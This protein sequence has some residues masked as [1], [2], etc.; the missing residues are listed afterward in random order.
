MTRAH[1]QTR[2]W[3][4]ICIFVLGFLAITIVSGVERMRAE[5]GL[6]AIGDADLPAA[7]DGRDAEAAFLRGTEEF[8]RSVLTEDRSGLDRVMLEG[9]RA[10]EL[11]RRIGAAH[12]ISDERTA[13]ARRLAA[14]LTQ[15]LGE[16]NSAYKSALPVQGETVLALRERVSGLTARTTV[17]KT[18]LRSLSTGLSGD[19]QQR[20]GEVR[21][22][23]AA[24]RVFVPCVFA[25]TMGL[26][27]TLVNLTVKRSILAPLAKTQD[28]L[29]HERDLLRILMD[30][31]PDCIY[32]KDAES[33]FLRI[34]RAQAAL[35]GLDDPA[36]ALGHSDADYFDA[37]VARR[38]LAD[39]QRVFQTGEPL[40]GSI[41]YVARKGL[42]RWVTSSKVRVHDEARNTNLIVGISR[43]ITEWKK[44]VEKLE[45]S[46]ESLRL[47]FA[48][49]PHAVWVYDVETLRFL[50]VNEAACRRYGYS[51]EEFERLRVSDLHPPAEASRLETTLAQLW[52]N[53]DQVLPQGAWQYRTQAG[54][55][56]EVDV[57]ARLL[58]F[59]D[60]PAM[61]AVVQDVSD[62]KRLELELQTSQRLEAVGHLAAGIAHEI[63]TPIQFVG[64]N[65][66][67][68]Q[69]AFEDRQAVIKRYGE[70]HRA[71]L[72]GEV[73]RAVLE[74]LEKA[75]Q[76][77]DMEYLDAEVPKA[78]EQSL[79][80]VERIATIVR[81]MKAFAHP[82][83]KE[84]VAADLNKALA[85]TLTV[86]RN[87]LKYVADVETDFG[88]LP[89]VV[90]H[91]ADL[92]Q[93]FLNILVN[94]AHAIGTVMKVSGVK[95]RI[96]V[97]TRLDGDR[98]TVSISDTGCGI[99]EAIRSRVFD[100]FFTTKEV[101]RGTGQGLALARSIVVEKHGGR[102]AFEPNPPQGTTFVVSVPTGQPVPVSPDAAVAVVE[103]MA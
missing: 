5:R 49:I 50:K 85:D 53:A 29:A 25:A 16:V 24:M 87:E 94:A 21:R 22:R 95:G 9:R 69:G 47:L 11:L 13:S 46:E 10:L 52:D 62:R 15:L 26:A 55:P 56:L 101:G 81:A 83:Q 77:A 30:H 63:N 40:V 86:A 32:F 100:Q 41:E 31:I 64:D 48:A 90:C 102:I 99:P 58:R 79:S 61:L 54:D 98:V 97:K 75:I 1:I 3:L 96:R 70:L 103:S 7:Q 2:V 73:P 6:A 59:K 74:D 34:N 89:P 8:S 39:E 27:I 36:E 82:G 28:E 84:K 19:M 42:A 44:T 17:F 33:K 12:G 23:S 91:L 37:Q 67:F 76:T 68:I 71:A 80:G 66:H 4:S 38:T 14:S 45:E 20:I 88:D 92:N 72:A 35:M 78:L 60:R 57:H 18:G 93:V 43:D 51:A 65:L